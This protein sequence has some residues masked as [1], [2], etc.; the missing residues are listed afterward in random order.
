[1]ELDPK[2]ELIDIKEDGSFLLTLPPSSVSSIILRQDIVP[3]KKDI[4]TAQA[5][6]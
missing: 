3:G 5:K 2:Q 4:Q 1:M 6:K